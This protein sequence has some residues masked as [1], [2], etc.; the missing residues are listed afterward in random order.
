MQSNLMR[1]VSS[2]AGLRKVN[3]RINLILSDPRFFRYVETSVEK[4]LSLSLVDRVAWETLQ[5]RKK[6]V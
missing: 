3:D 1:L 6:K 5:R 4:G 2:P